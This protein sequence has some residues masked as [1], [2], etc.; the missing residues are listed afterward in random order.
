MKTVE[1]RK[2]DVALVTCAEL[3]AL[4]PDDRLLLAALEA[5]GLAAAPAVWDAPEFDW[6]RARLCLLRSTWDYSTRLQEFLSWAASVAPVTQLWNPLPVI[7]WNAHKS[8]LYR[9][10]A[11]GVHV[12]PTVLLPAGSRTNL[13]RMLEANHW[14]DAIIKPAVSLSARETMRVSSRDPLP[15]QAHLERLLATEDVMVQP[16]FPSVEQEGELS[17]MFIEGEC[18]HAVCKRPAA[19]DYRVQEE[20]GGTVESIEPSGPALSLAR[21]ALNAAGFETL[22]A[23]ADL[24]AGADGRLRVVEL[25]LIEPSLFFGHFPAAVEQLA[26]ALVKRLP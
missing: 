21:Q 20:F 23:R 16:F 17:L 4:V 25:E 8:Y 7:R 22:Y 9:L 26:A 1:R 2:V 6:A 14:Q 3:P 5:R 13:D 18:T 19:G 15:A 10:A 24:M 11:R 12:V